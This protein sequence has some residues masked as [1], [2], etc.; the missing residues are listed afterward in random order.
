MA[1]PALRGRHRGG[2]TIHRSGRILYVE[3]TGPFDG[4]MVDTVIEAYRPFIAE[5]AARGAFGHI[6][7]FHG[8]MVVTPDGIRAFGRLLDAWRASGIESVAN[9][10]VAPPGIEGRD[11]MMPLLGGLFRSP[12]REFEAIADAERWIRDELASAQ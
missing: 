1:P 4:P 7:L 9:A 10:Y 8:S 11:T 2:M 6:S 3:S 5:L 12:F